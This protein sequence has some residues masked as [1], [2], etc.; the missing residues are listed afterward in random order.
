MTEQ[1]RI[2]IVWNHIERLAFKPASPKNQKAWLSICGRSLH[3]LWEC[4]PISSPL[5]HSLTNFDIPL[6]GI[7]WD[8]S[9]VNSTKYDLSIKTSESILWTIHCDPRY[10]TKPVL[11]PAESYPN[12]RTNQQLEHDLKKVLDGMIF[13]PR[14]H[15][16]LKEIG[17]WATEKNLPLL[18]EIRISSAEPNPFVFMFQLRYQFCITSKEKREEEKA[19]LTTLFLDAIKNGRAVPPS[20]LFDF[21][22]GR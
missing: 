9:I 12:P 4:D 10:E 11:A 20:C 13:H 3:K 21:K 1:E 16:H 7:Q 14:C 15:S 19:R 22:Q 18:H 5:K 6:L 8:Y 2:A 17:S